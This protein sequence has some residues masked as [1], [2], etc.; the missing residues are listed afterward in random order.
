MCLCG[1]YLYC[2]DKVIK[3]SSEILRLDL[4]ADLEEAETDEIGDG[5]VLVRDDGVGCVAEDYVVELWMPERDLRPA[6][7]IVKEVLKPE[8]PVV[9][10]GRLHVKIAAG[11]RTVNYRKVA[12]I[13]FGSP[14][15]S[16]KW[17]IIST[18][19]LAEIA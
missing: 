7:T 11:R 15:L 1:F 12:P 14:F 2:T 17:I 10:R 16:L 13:A 6:L 3:L 9:H 5:V 18:L 19:F 4:N 8:S